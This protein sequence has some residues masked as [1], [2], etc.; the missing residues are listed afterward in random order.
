MAGRHPAG[1]LADG[2]L[3]HRAQQAGAHDLEVDG[4]P[5]GVRDVD[6]ERQRRAH[7][8]VLAEAVERDGDQLLG[9]GVPGPGVDADGQVGADAA[10]RRRGVQVAA[11]AGRGSRPG[12][13]TSSST[14]SARAAASDVAAAVGPGLV[15]QR[16]GWTGAW[17]RQR[18]SPSICRTKT[19]CTS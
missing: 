6:P 18:F 11:R 5:G 17:M 7:L 10:E 2:G 15:A 13:S 16:A 3:L 12:R 4:E 1:D 14:G 19:S 8:L 9:Q